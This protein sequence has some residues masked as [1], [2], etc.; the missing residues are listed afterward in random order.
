M[1]KKATTLRTAL[2]A[3][4]AIIAVSLSSMAN[5][6]STIAADGTIS[7]AAALDGFL[8]A[9][10]QLGTGADLAATVT[11]A[12]RSLSPTSSTSITNDQTILGNEVTAQTRLNQST[13][14]LAVSTPAGSGFTGA[15]A[16]EDGGATSV[17]SMDAGIGILSLQDAAGGATAQTYSA[18][19]TS[20]NNTIA[21][22]APTISGVLALGGNQTIAD[23]LVNDAT[24]TITATAGGTGNVNVPA[25]I[26]NLQVITPGTD[27]TDGF[28][29]DIAATVT[30]A[31]TVTLTN[32]T[33]L[34]GDVR[35]DENAIGA[36]AGANTAVNDLFAG[37][38]DGGAIGGLTGT[39]SSAALDTAG[40]ITS[41]V[42]DFTV[43][44]LQM[45][46]KT[47]GATG[48]DA[49]GAVN[50]N[51]ITTGSVGLTAPV[52]AVTTSTL[53]T[54]RSNT[55]VSE[56]AGNTATNRAIVT[57]EGLDGVSVGV[58]SAQEATGLGTADITA[59]TTGNI[60]M[61]GGELA[62]TVVD[63]SGN[64]IGANAVANEAL[65]V[66]AITSTGS[67]GGSTGYVAGRQTATDME[68]AATVASGDITANFAEAAGGS[69]TMS[70]NNVYATAALNTQSNIAQNIGSSAFGASTMASTSR[71]AIVGGG[72]T[73]TIT[74]ADIGLTSI[75]D[76]STTT[77]I[78]N[79]AVMASA[80][81]NVSTTSISNRNAS[82]SFTR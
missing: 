37:G 62:S 15:T 44:N 38:A 10:S 61:T 54:A 21:A 26:A 31:N 47:A 13:V 59:S 60:T 3:S 82:F 80:T 30:G 65:N 66:A 20:G 57:T 24:N 14:N 75:G 67:L 2:L 28:D 78:A 33:A 45:L 79:N 32:T 72:V 6:Q 4:S 52:G 55:I 81:G 77:S 39:L 25:A 1:T 58:A 50:L 17:A 19:V 49:S 69:V 53:I 22:D 70:G 71:Q 43:A 42:G 46:E 16:L 34:S 12:D 68:V 29:I 74:S 40:K 63:M 5:A 23:V 64:T 35:L 8:A 36:R 41:F 56:A 11:G 18:T 76:T 9:T 51:A 73:A 48:T 27:A 7:V